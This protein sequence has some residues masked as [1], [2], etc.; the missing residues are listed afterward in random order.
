M[1]ISNPKDKIFTTLLIVALVGVMFAFSLPCP[2]RAL[3]H[4][5]CPGCGMT[6][7]YFS[8]LHGNIRQA[9]AYHSMFWSVP[10]IYVM[11]LFDGKLFGRKWADGILTA[12]LTVGWLGNWLYHLFWVK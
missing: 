3:L 1:K 5:Y 11:Y 7:A 6:R 10:I 9:F 4:I 12:A 2:F 8:L